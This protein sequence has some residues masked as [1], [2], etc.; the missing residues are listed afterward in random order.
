LLLLLLLFLLLL[1]LLLLLLWLPALQITAATKY[2]DYA[3][4]MGR[5]VNFPENFNGKAPEDLPD[6][7]MVR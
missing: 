5:P 2:D 7:P 4:R 6:I 3:A 1:L